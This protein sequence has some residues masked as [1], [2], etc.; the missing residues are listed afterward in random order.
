MKNAD[1]FITDRLSEFI[2]KNGYVPQKFNPYNCAEIVDLAPTLLT[3]CGGLTV[4]ST[5]L[6]IREFY[7]PENFKKS[8]VR[9]WQTDQKRI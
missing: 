4:S 1:Q 9:V 5:V 8:E 7:V 6:I 2:E 3:N